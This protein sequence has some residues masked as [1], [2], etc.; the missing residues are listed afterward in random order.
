MASRPSENVA[1]RLSKSVARRPSGSVASRLSKSVASRPSESVATMPA[2]IL[3]M[4]RHGAFVV[5]VGIGESHEILINKN[6]IIHE[7]GL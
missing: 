5:S 3:V 7:C 1:S 2:P 6:C 4:F